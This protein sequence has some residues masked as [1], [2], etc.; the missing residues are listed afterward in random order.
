[1]RQLY[2]QLKINKSAFN[3]RHTLC[4]SDLRKSAT[5]KPIYSSELIK[6]SEFQTYVRSEPDHL[7]G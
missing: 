7:L 5:V 1:V 4:V 3:F 6:T 2:F